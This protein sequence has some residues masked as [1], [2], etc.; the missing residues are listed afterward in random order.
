MDSETVLITITQ[1]RSTFPVFL[2]DG[3]V[4]VEI[5][6]FLEWQGTGQGEAVFSLKE[7]I[8]G[9]IL[10]GSLV[11]CKDMRRYT[12]PIVLRKKY[13]DTSKE[14]TA[15]FPEDGYTIPLR[16][17]SLLENETLLL[18]TGDFRLGGAFS[19]V[20]PVNVAGVSSEATFLESD[21]AVV[22]IGGKGRK[23]FSGITFRSRSLSKGNVVVVQSGEVLFRDCRFTGG[24]PEKV[25]W[26]GN[27]LVITGSSRVTLERCSLFRNKSCG[28][29]VNKGAR[30]LFTQSRIF[31]N[32]REGIAVGR[33][34]SVV[35][36]G[37]HVYE[38]SWGVSAGGGSAVELTGNFIEDNRL[39]GL[40]FSA[41]A[42]GTVRG[43]RVWNNQ[44]GV[45]C[46]PQTQI[47]FDENDL[48]NNACDFLRQE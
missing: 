41:L 11:F 44:V 24:L 12:L 13:E 5:P 7:R 43:N 35:C 28:M 22:R 29:I 20:N 45:Y 36:R 14:G 9:R 18:G 37:S 10:Q 27:G 46:H 21:G 15:L 25:G 26:M 1:E 33:D 3:A 31:S 2:G 8:Q 40:L 34:G 23:V 19:I 47:V 4:L 16:L 48:Q 6:S 32:G 42:E 38:N 39:G 30:V 17:E